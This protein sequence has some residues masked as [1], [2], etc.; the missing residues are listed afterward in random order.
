MFSDIY[1][2]ERAFRDGG[3]WDRLRGTAVPPGAAQAEADVPSVTDAPS[4]VSALPEDQSD[5]AQLSLFSNWMTRV[6]DRLVHVV[7]TEPE[8][9]D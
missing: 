7:T 1:E 3:D 4:I 8:A 6:K 2:I 9:A 5:G